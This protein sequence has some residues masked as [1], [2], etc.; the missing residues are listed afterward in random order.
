MTSRYSNYFSPEASNIPPSVSITNP[1]DN[2]TINTNAVNVAANV[3]DA[4]GSVTRVEFYLNGTL[5]ETKTTAPYSSSLSPLNLGLN[6]IMV[7][8]FDNSN[9]SSTSS[10]NV[11]Y[12]SSTG[13]GNNCDAA[14][15]SSSKAYLGGDKVHYDGYIYTAAYWSQNSRP[16]QN[17]GLYGKPWLNNRVACESTPSLTSPTISITT[18][19]NGTTIYTNSVEVS[20]TANAP[21]G[22]ISKVEFYLNGILKST[23]TVSPYVASLSALNQGQNSIKAIVHDNKGQTAESIVAVNYS[24]Q[25]SNTPPTVSISSPVNNSTVSTT[26]VNL[27]ANASDPDGSIV[28]VEFYLNG[29]LKSTD[30]TAPYSASITGLTSGSNTITAKATDDKGA[31]VN[32]TI[33]INYQLSG[34]DDCMGVAAWSSTKIYNA[35]DRVK[36]L[37]VIYKADYWTQ[38]NRPSQN[39]GSGKPWSV[40]SKCD[41]T[42]DASAFGETQICGGIKI[43]IWKADDVYDKPGTKVVHEGKIY[44]CKYWTKGNLPSLGGAWS[45]VGLCQ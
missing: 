11:T 38:N 19:A 8:A 10:V 41:G 4:D 34:G 2:A 23:K 20:T 16:D 22:S 39:H 30:T 32:S 33:T 27:A 42:L 13:G 44:E 36:E 21:S 7:K 18:P 5:K 43:L 12:T 3:S 31:T 15:W 14:E 37:D 9:A 17:Y 26:S 25:V 24:A 40:V 28:K 35:G 6:S 45:L 29:L 1:L